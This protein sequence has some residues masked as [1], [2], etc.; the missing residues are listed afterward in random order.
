MSLHFSLRLVS[1][2]RGNWWKACILN[3][4]SVYPWVQVGF[5]NILAARYE[6]DKA[7]AHIFSSSSPWAMGWLEISL[8]QL[9]KKSWSNLVGRGPQRSIFRFGV[10]F[11]VENWKWIM[12]SLKPNSRFAPP[13]FFHNPKRKGSSSNSS[14]LRRVNAPSFLVSNCQKK[15]SPWLHLG[16]VKTPSLQKVHHLWSG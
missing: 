16:A 15:K 6:A 8:P 5:C 11:W 2:V 7:T 12:H 14:I 10:S 1:F 3:T 4:L 13:I 9:G